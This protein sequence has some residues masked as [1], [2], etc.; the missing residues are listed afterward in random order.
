MRMVQQSLS[1]KKKNLRNGRTA[2]GLSAVV[3]GM[4][5]LAFASEPLYRIFC[6]VTGYAGTTQ[7]A[8][9]APLKDEALD[10]IVAVRVDANVNAKLPWR[11]WPVQ[12]EMDVRVGE[13]AL[14]FFEATN[15]SDEPIVGTASFNVTPYK[16]A[17][18]F[19]KIDCFCF[20]QQV[21]MPGQTVQM[22]VTF[23]VDG[24]ITKDA[25][26]IDLRTITLSYTFFQDED[27]SAAEKLVAKKIMGK[28]EAYN[29]P[30]KANSNG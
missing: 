25:S 13:Q 12:R 28:D 27:Q 30:V 16:A 11:F 15:L 20:T 19:N 26:A 1:Q 17:I 24:E 18:H 5:G 22:P 7:V 21:L 8:S 29:K 23:F 14:A 9:E 10:R 6:Q 4:V 3:V 2:I